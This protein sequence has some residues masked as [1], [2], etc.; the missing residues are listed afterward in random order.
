VNLFGVL[1]YHQGISSLQR[2]KKKIIISEYV[3]FLEST[4][5]K[6]TIEQGIDHLDRFT[7]V[8]TY[9]EFDN[10]IPHLEGGIPILDQSLEYPFEIPYP[11]H[12]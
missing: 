9:H 10:E 7:H 12:I 2:S 4:K 11:T 3:V 8:N 5:N 6:K 1:K